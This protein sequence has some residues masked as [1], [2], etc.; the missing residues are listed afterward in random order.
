MRKL[1]LVAAVITALAFATAT[2]IAAKDPPPHA[3]RG[4]TRAAQET[5]AHVPG[6]N[7]P[8]ASAVQ[9]VRETA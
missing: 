8:D 9:K 1:V 7:L 5:A 6:A 2:P 4:L 3:E